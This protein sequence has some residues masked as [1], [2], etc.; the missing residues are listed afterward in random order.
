MAN[1]IYNQLVP[2]IHWYYIYYALTIAPYLTAPAS[3]RDSS[4]EQKNVGFS[5]SVI[6]Y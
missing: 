4:V 6:A 3:E 1:Y 5:T 2:D